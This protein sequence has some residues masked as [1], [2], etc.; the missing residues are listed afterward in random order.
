MASLTRGEEPVGLATIAH[1]PWRLALSFLSTHFDPRRIRELYH[2]VALLHKE[3]AL[4][5]WLISSTDVES[6]VQPMPYGADEFPITFWVEDQYIEMTPTKALASV[7][8]AWLQGFRAGMRYPPQYLCIC[9]GGS[10]NEPCPIHHY[11]RLK[12][13]FWSWLKS[14]ITSNS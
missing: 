14:V 12:H 2:Q 8:E 9:Y 13:A 6:R 7:K 4:V 11:G 10:S 3:P 1:I 5:H